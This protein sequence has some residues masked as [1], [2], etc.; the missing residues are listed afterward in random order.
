M[1]TEEMKTKRMEEDVAFIKDTSKWPGEGGV[2]CLKRQPWL[3]RGKFP[4]GFGLLIAGETERGVWFVRSYSDGVVTHKYT[5]V[6][7]MVKE[8][9]VD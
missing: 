5:S 1:I 8:W 9:T 3:E 7:E 6:E 4:D 2:C